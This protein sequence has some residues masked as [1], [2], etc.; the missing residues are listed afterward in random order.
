MTDVTRI[1]A[2]IFSP[3]PSVRDEHF[4]PIFHRW[5]R[6]RM[7]GG[8]LIDVADYTH[9]P[10]GPGVMLVG[11]E[12][13]FSLDRAD[14]RFGLAAQRR[15]PFEGDAVDG[16]VATLES[17]FAAAAALERDAPDVGLA[18]DRTRLRIELNDRLRGPNSDAAFLELRP[19]VAAA[20]RRAWPNRS[21][22]V[23]RS[24]NDARDRLAMDV[25]ISLGEA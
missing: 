11:H 5:I 4:V 16:I 19:M 20:A 12:V 25:L 6:G 22:V 13:T 18:L 17:L 8:V 1:Y 21:V 10:E 15:R 3:E 7:L 14:G 23:E 9:V 2:K 24:V